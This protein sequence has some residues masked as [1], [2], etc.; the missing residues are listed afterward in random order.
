MGVVVEFGS[1]HSPWEG[2]APIENCVFVHATCP[3]PF[4]ELYAR[5]G[6]EPGFFNSEKKMTLNLLFEPPI[7]MSMSCL[8]KIEASRNKG[9]LDIECM[10]RLMLARMK[11]KGEEEKSSSSIDSR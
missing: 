11:M 6:I 3:G 5:E 8:A 7:S 4:N 10:K 9:T 1:D 2:F